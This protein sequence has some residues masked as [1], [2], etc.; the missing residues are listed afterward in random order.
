M[1]KHLFIAVLVS[2]SASLSAADFNTPSVTIHAVT[3][4]L[5]HFQN[6]FDQLQSGD[7]LLLDL[8][9]TVFRE[10]Q[11]LGTD[12]WYD[13]AIHELLRKYNISRR[14]ASAQLE[15]LN[16]SIKENSEMRLM[17]N[18]LPDLILHLQQRGVYVLGLTARHPNL[19]KT[20]LRHLATLG[21][22]FGRSQFPSIR[23]RHVP[24][25]ENDFRFSGGIAF[26]DGS[27]KGKIL[28]FLVEQIDKKPQMIMAVDDRI[29]HIHT[30]VENMLE[31]EI[32][33]HVI[34]YLKVREEPAFDPEI[35]RVQQQ[36]FEQTGQLLTDQEAVQRKSCNSLLETNPPQLAF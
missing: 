36:V 32:G 14:E 28:K 11:L 30:L 7:M 1:I 33:G 6:K 23:E 17:E 10:K 21:I 4:L 13:Y 26:T 19:T 27:P 9:N 18:R 34:H 12:E 2:F 29:H 15:S 16:L 20:T 22:D 31:L 3:E 25:L 8:D 5:P 35:A 24:G